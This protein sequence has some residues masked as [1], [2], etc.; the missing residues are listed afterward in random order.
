VDQGDEPGSL[1]SCLSL[2]GIESSE[3]DP[4]GNRVCFIA[5]A[6][7]T[8]GGIYAL[9][10]NTREVTFVT[11]GNLYVVL[12]GELRRGKHLVTKHKY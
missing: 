2:E 4:N 3:F 12:R 10:L 11:D 8:S 7:V 1:R 6:W 5:D 9:D